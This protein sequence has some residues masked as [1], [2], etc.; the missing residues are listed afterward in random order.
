[1]IY[2]LDPSSGNEEILFT[3]DDGPDGGFP[4]GPMILDPSGKVLFGVTVSGGD[5]FNCSGGCGT[6]FELTP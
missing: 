6:V 3:F 1:M 5:L 4:T 2:S